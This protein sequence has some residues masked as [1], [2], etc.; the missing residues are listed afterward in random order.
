MTATAFDNLDDYVALPRVS[1]LALS[2]DGSRLVTTVAELDDAG[3]QH[4]SAIWELDPAGRRPANRLTRSP[5]G[6]SSPTFTPDGDLIFLSSRPTADEAK[7]PAALW[8]LPATGGEAIEVAGLPSAITAV[9]AARAAAKTVIGASMLPAARDVDDDR[10]LRDLRKDGRV[11]AIL[12][13]GYPVRFWNADIGPDQPH[14]LDVDGLRDLTPHPGAALLAAGFGDSAF[15]VSADGSFLVT[16]W[17]L[18]GPGPTQRSVLMRIDLASGERRVIVDDPD[19][20]LDHPVIAPDGSAVA[21]TRETI[22]TPD[23]APRMTLQCLRFGDEPRPL[24]EDW[25]RRPS[26]IRWAGDGAA[27]I[28]TADQSGRAP[29]FTVDVASRPADRRRLRLRRCR[30]RTRRRALRLAEFLCGTATS[31]AHRSRRHDHDAAVH[32]LTGAARNF[33]RSVHHNRRRC[34]GAVVAGA[35]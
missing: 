21:F 24:A 9:R 7:P 14:L 15:D 27:L 31:G 32:R 4:V 35:A 29:V 12:H 17:Q 11:T 1:G 30:R 26:S 13:T 10:R 5:N 18:T 22:T 28:V 34:D 3:A 16:T 2:A 20:S 25:D 8:R 23:C 6:E 19:A 33:D